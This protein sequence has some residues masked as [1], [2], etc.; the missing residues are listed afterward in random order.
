[1]DLISKFNRLI[2][3]K[4]GIINALRSKGA[5]V[6]NDAGYASY[7]NLV[8]SLFTDGIVVWTKR[9]DDGNP[10][11]IEIRQN[12]SSTLYFKGHTSLEKV[13]IKPSLTLNGY[14]LY[15]DGCTSLETI[16]DADNVY[17]DT[18]YP[19][20]SFENCESLINIDCILD[21]GERAYE[22]NGYLY[23]KF[24][25][26][27]NLEYDGLL[28][29]YG[30]ESNFENCYKLNPSQ[31][32]IPYNYIGEKNFKNCTSLS[33]TEL[34]YDSLSSSM[35]VENEAF[36]GCTNLALTKLENIYE[37]YTRAFYG[38]TSLTLEDGITSNDGVMRLDEECFA[39][40]TSLQLS[41]LPE[42]T[43][44][45]SIRCFANSGITHME[46]P[47]SVSSFITQEAFDGCANLVDLVKNGTGRV[48]IT[49]RGFRNCTSLTTVDFSEVTDDVSLWEGSFSGCTSLSTFKVDNSDELLF[50]TD[51]FKG[52]AF[53]NTD[54][55]ISDNLQHVEIQDAFINCTQLT[56]FNVQSENMTN[57]AMEYPDMFSGCTS[58][59][60]ITLYA[61]GRNGSGDPDIN[62]NPNAFRGVPI[63]TINVSWSIGDVNDAPWGAD[64]ATITYDYIPGA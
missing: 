36:Y 28:N 18:Y 6:P 45:N 2:A 39:N 44:L 51:A 52:C 25:N 12:P 1:M 37:I 14:S 30:G 9:D 63:T 34:L 32:A 59:T 48:Q 64:N 21:A 27:Y 53:T 20:A 26:C 13:R 35:S 8:N 46:I 19:S 38:C 22:H 5:T 55:L 29:V 16:E 40:C 3:T 10:T 33:V 60:T 41:S 62:I 57:L 42:G 23:G 56:R 17:S 31:L 24:T 7:P 11:V 43:Y 4:S 58:L 50:E 49:F 61:E 54:F 47:D 15:F